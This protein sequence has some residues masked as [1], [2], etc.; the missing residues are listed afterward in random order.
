MISGGTKRDQEREFGLETRY[1]GDEG[2]VMLLAVELSFF[3]VYGLCV[4]ERVL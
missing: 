4:W 3:Q 1:L 2:V